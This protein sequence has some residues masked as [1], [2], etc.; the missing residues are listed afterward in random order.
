MNTVRLAAKPL[1]STEQDHP[2]MLSRIIIL[3]VAFTVLVLV[4]RFLSIPYWGELVATAV[5]V[6]VMTYGL[7]RVDGRKPSDPASG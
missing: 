2:R 6:G 5:V 3:A 4:N 7:G 1:S